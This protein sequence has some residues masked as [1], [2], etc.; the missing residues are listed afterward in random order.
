MQALAEKKKKESEEVTRKYKE[1]LGIKDE[2]SSE[3]SGLDA[4]DDDDDEDFEVHSA[5][6]KQEEKK[7]S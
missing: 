3:I 7:V 1:K 2:E 5:S 6:S 4:A